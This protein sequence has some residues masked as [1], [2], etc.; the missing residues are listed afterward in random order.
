MIFQTFILIESEN[1]GTNSSYS[2]DLRLLVIKDLWHIASCSYTNNT[3]SPLDLIEF[4][5]GFLHH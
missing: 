3:K 4:N 1:L 5:N 2:K